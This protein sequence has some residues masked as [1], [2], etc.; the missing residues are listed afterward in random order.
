MCHSLLNTMRLNSFRD[1]NLS[2]TIVVAILGGLLLTEAFVVKPLWKKLKTHQL[3]KARATHV[4]NTN[5]AP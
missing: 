2:F 3:N 4:Q 1:S 5:S